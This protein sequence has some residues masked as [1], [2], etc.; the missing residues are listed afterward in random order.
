MLK[1]NLDFLVRVLS[2]AVF[3][4]VWREALEKLQDILWSEV[5][6]RQ[7]F[8]M[9]G[10][11]QFMRDVQAICGLLERYIPDGSSALASI[12]EAVT[13]LNLP[14]DVDEKEFSE[15]EGR[16]MT[17]GEATDRMTT[18]YA[19]A[20]QTLEELGLETLTPYNAR[21]ILQRRIENSD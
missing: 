10:S 3:R 1:R 6:M 8:S 14:L 21:N 18:D 15:R 13:L 4:R 7:R 17:L 16:P 11:A 2:T 5:L 20:K 9:H 19:I 12:Q